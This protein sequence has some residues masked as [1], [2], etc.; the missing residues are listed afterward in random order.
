VN[1]STPFIRRPIATILLTIGV[2]LAGIGAFFVL[3]VAP[4]PQVDFPVISVQASLPGASP[5]T[6]A[7][8][9]A[10]PLERRLGIIPGVNEMSSNSGTGSTRIN[11][12]FDLSRDING[13]AR[14]VQAAINAAH[15]DLPTTMRSNPTYR[16]ENPSEAPMMVLALTSDTKT[17]GQI[18]EAVSNIVEQKIGGGSLPAVRVELNPLTLNQYGVSMEDVRTALQNSNANRPKGIVAGDGRRF[19][20][21]TN[22]SG[23]KASD[24]R[25]LVVGW[26]N[27]APVRLQDIAEVIDS[28][29]DTRTIGMINGQP[30]VLVL[31]LRQPGANIVATV[32]KVRTLI[33]ELRS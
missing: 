6:M 19:Q 23:R 16:K 1:L 18:Y 9:I 26:R 5:Q 21:Y 3:P 7:S 4:L 14:E 31:I 29:E 20:I 28:V 13:A 32:D 24:Y 11:L 27:N 22:D 15:S 8:S 33:P 12:Q 2:A 25:P 17:P 10:T 30:G